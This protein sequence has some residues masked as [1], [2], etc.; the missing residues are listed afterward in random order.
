MRVRITVTLMLILQGS[1]SYNFFDANLLTVFCKLDLFIAM[2]QILLMFIKWPSL[3]KGVS[4]FSPKS[5]I[6]LTPGH[7]SI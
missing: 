4:K 2:E 7:A 1:I 6:R 3:Q 5:F